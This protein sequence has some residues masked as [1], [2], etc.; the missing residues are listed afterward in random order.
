M[1]ETKNAN[2]WLAHVAQFRAKH[3]EL[4]YKQCLIEAAKPDAGYTK[5]EKEVRDPD[6]P[7]K[8]NPWMT[9]VQKFKDHNPNW[10]EVMTYKAVLMHCKTFY[11][12]ED[13]DYAMPEG[14]AL[15][16]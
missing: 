15:T 5:V 9:H 14:V 1:T 16:A 10:R 7:T 2:V 13:K 12:T 11:N 4:T 6:A 3:P 8:E